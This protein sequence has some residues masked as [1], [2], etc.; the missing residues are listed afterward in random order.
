MVTVQPS[1]AALPQPIELPTEGEWHC[2]HV[3]PQ[4]EF[5]FL[6]ELEARGIFAF[7]PTI[8]RHGQRVGRNVVTRDVPVFIGYLFIRGSADDAYTARTYAV[9]PRIVREIPI[10]NQQEFDSDMRAIAAAVNSGRVLGR[11]AIV[12]GRRVEVVRGSLAGT[13]GV[14]VRHGDTARLVIECRL[15]N[16]ALEVEVDESDVELVDCDEPQVA[17]HSA[18][19][20]S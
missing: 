13:Q 12:P 1:P 10:T 16:R 6:K 14:I 9:V 2:F 15:L 17:G 4:C 11:S 7:L 3:R 19:R 18:R 20:V 8:R 5:V